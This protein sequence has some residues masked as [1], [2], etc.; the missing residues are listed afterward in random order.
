MST[1]R[2]YLVTVIHN[3]RVYE[4]LAKATTVDAALRVALK[5]R[6]ALRDAVRRGE[7]SWEARWA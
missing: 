4:M 6:R 1:P 3:G 7:A 5:E 2:D